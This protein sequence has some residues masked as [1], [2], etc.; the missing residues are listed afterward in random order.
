VTFFVIIVRPNHYVLD[1]VVAV[2]F[3]ALGTCCSGCCTAAGVRVVLA[4]RGG[5]ASPPAALPIRAESGSALS[6]RR[7]LGLPD[8]VPA[9]GERRQSRRRARWQS[10]ARDV[11]GQ[12]LMSTGV[13]VGPEAGPR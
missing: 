4:G 5:D 13:D 9:C 6:A 7:Q 1:A 8:D 2:F 3:L 12:T 11:Q 10:Q